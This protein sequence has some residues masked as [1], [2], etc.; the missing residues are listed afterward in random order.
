MIIALDVGGSSVKS[1]VVDNDSRVH[2]IRSTALDSKGSAE[3]ILATLAKIVTNYLQQYS[4]VRGIGIGFPGPFDYD[5]GISLIQGVDK[6]EAIFDINIG[7]AIR[8]RLEQENVLIRFRN[9]AEAA[10]IGEAVYGAGRPFSRFIGVT[11][12]TGIGSSFIVDGARVSSGK[13]IPDGGFLFPVDFQGEQADEWFSTR[14]LLRRFQAVDE[15]FSS[16][17]EAAQSESPAI[18]QAF[19]EFGEDMAAFL[20]PF[21]SEFEA[22]ALLVSG[23]IAAAYPLF[24]D[25]LEANVNVPVVVGELGTKAALLGA[26]D[27]ILRPN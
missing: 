25:T 27:L 16:V 6:Y 14:G 19:A 15:P 7:D 8:E 4:S 11:L 24:G 1:G 26:A 18:K 21:L 17:S 2:D 22:D 23:G 3:N 5:K 20:S 9:D 10:L 13:G 12:G